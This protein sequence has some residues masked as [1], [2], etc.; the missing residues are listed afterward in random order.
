M[1]YRKVGVGGGGHLQG[2]GLF[3]GSTET[4]SFDVPLLRPTLVFLLLLFLRLVFS[5]KKIKNKTSFTTT[6][7]AN[8]K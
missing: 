6:Q 5:L 8:T 1:S 7:M 4:I 3:R 2:E